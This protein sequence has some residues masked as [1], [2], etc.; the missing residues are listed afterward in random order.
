MII[1]C[2]QTR[3]QG[4][5]LR[6]V[7]LWMCAAI[8]LMMVPACDGDGGADGVEWKHPEENSMPAAF[9]KD[10]SVP[11]YAEQWRMP[12]GFLRFTAR[13]N[14]RVRQHVETSLKAKQ[15]E[16]RDALAA[17]LAARPGSV[18]YKT[19]QIRFCA[20]LESCRRLA[21]RR[22]RGQ[23]LA[24]LPETM[25]PQN[26]NWQTGMEQP[27]L[28]SPEATKG[29]TI[30]LT[31][32]RSFPNTFRI[33]GPN[34]NNATRRYIY[35]D[36]DMPL[37]RLHPATGKLIPGT[38][39]RW[40]VSDDGLTV[41]FHIDEKARFSDGSPLTSRDFITALYV[42]A[43]EYSLEPFYGDY[44]LNTFARIATYGNHVVAVTLNA[45][46]NIPAYY[47]SIP[48]SCT[49]FYAEY[50]PD[51]PTRYLWRTEPTTGAYV[52]DA[53]Q[54]IM[55]RQIGL[56]RVKDWWARN[57]KFTRYSCNVDHIIY[58]FIAEQTKARELFRIG[59]LDVLSARDADAWYEGL[60]IPAVH[61]GYIQRVHFSNMWP[62]NCFGFHL[63]CSRP[64]TDDI[65]LRKGLHHALNV[66]AVI[67]TIFRGD[68]ERLGS[69]FSGFGEYTDESI[70]ALP[71]NPEKARAYFAKAGYTEEGGDGILQKPDGTRLQVVVS[72]RIDALY[73]NC[74]NLLREDAAKCGLDLRLEQMDDTVFYI[75]VKEKNY[76][77][78]LFSWG[79]SPP[80]PT[81][82][83][84]FLSR[85]AYRPDGLPAKNT[86]NITA[87]AS[88]ELDAAI[89]D[90][91]DAR[92][93][94]AAVKAHHRVQC[95]IAETAAWVPG[96]TTSY[97]RFAQWRWVRWPDTATCRFCPPRF[98]DPLDSH[99]YW[100]D[101]KIKEKTL[102][103]RAAGKIYA[104]TELNIPLPDNTPNS[105]TA[106]P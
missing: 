45:P 72:S 75:K 89:M 12:K 84:F 90:T 25:L 16:Q 36:I 41:Y 97:W 42:R 101:E 103:A 47:A 53:D 15:A 4:A 71:Y 94:D 52:L 69:Y 74:L 33:F 31:L 54:L 49:A 29:G 13:W 17:M 39:D 50:G 104:E 20:A 60:E 63:N 98:Y 95:L 27:E 87:T 5:P 11:V 6:L 92:T 78:A 105:T 85:Y 58:S 62:R 55:G 37:V 66:Q 81:P 57:R 56:K 67:N 32:Q 65:N 24:Y 26:L 43:S 88:P 38:A 21:R 83:N 8:L 64:P 28:G 99:L 51:F 10:E 76:T 73:A 44:Y 23:Y 34:S 22:N 2:E 102:R 79:F 46:R 93:H 14:E 61:N 30:R 96:W 18:E 40:A 9:A 82:A 59:E 7:W 68:Y 3:K 106:K 91:E 77:A 1:P 100:I 86:S 80:V 48:A 35:D 70:R 19:A